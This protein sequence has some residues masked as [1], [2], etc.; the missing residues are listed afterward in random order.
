MNSS[1][2]MIFNNNFEM[3]SPPD[4]RQMSM[5]Y[6]PPSEEYNLINF[7]NKNQEEVSKSSSMININQNISQFTQED[8]K[9][10]DIKEFIPKDENNNSNN[11]DLFFSLAN[12]QETGHF[13]FIQP[14]SNNILNSYQPNNVVGAKYNLSKQS[15]ENKNYNPNN[16]MFSSMPII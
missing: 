6:L 1:P 7:T 2:N 11:T 5:A 3:S 12:E 8:N 10:S 13:N 4:F 16:N 15:I 9:E 14:K